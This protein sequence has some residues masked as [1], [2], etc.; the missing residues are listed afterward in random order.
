[1]KKLF[2]LIFAA[3]L[4]AAFTTPAMAK[5]NI[6]CVIATDF[7]Y[8]KSDA[9]HKAGGVVTA[10]VAAIPGDDNYSQTHIQIPGWSR[11]NI[12]WT[13]E[14]DV[15]ARI[16]FGVGD[17]GAGQLI[18]G[19][20]GTTGGAT[21]RHAYGEWDVTPGF[22]L[23]AGWSTTPF[24]PLDPTQTLGT[25]APNFI[26]P[27][28]G[29]GHIIGIGFG[30]FYSGRFPQVRGTWKFSDQMKFEMALV[31]PAVTATPF[32]AAAGK[33]SDNE[34]KMPRIDASADL[35]FGP[36]K[37]YP[38]I[39]WH[40]QIYDNVTA[41][42]DNEIT[43]YG[44][45]LGLRFNIGPVDFASEIQTGQNWSNTRGTLPSMW[46]T[47]GTIIGAT[48]RVSPTGQVL[49]SDDLGWWVDVSFKLGMVTP[50]LLYGMSRTDN[51]GVPGIADDFEVNTK[52]Y[53]IHVVIPVAKTFMIRPE[54]MIYDYGDDNQVGV[55]APVGSTVDFGKQTIL[56]VQF[57]VV[58]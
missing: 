51:D 35:Y 18:S 55:A 48:T 57:M 36:L 38:S 54:F 40:K 33:V 49:D 21:L 30:N 2:V 10:P 56:G 53:G 14:K 7:Y 46:D 5:F 1:M 37:L 17:Q 3:L 52:M 44:Y 6:G 26:P 25:S 39:F 4:V 34:S 47:S 20:G 9:E 15:R 58:F 8:L 29:L 42:S 16:E 27:F 11:P 45:S 23:M 43:S 32:A 19:A 31:D 28:L 12:T 41:G 13:N 24:S 50:H 22:T